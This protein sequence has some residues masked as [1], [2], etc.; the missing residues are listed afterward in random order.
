M[1]KHTPF[2]TPSTTASVPLISQVLT[3]FEELVQSQEG[4]STPPR[5][6]GCPATLQIPH[7]LLACLLQMRRKTFSP[8]A[9]TRTLLLEPIGGFAPLLSITRQAGRQ[10]LLAVGLTPFIHLLHQVQ[11]DLTRRGS[12][13]NALPLAA[14]ASMV[15]AVDESELA[16]V[17]RL[18][19]EVALLPKHSE[20]LLVGKLSALFDLRRQLWLHVHLLSDPFGNGTLPALL[21]LE[22]LPAGSLILADLGYFG[23]AWFQY[24][25]EQGQ[26][27]LS[28][29]KSTSSYRIQHILYQRGD[30][31]DALIWLGT[32]R[33]NQYPYLVRW[34]QDRVGN[35]LYR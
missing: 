27:W 25:S 17:A 2:P 18:C 10:R 14:F 28:R 24:L 13:N 20:R 35:S 30:T 15:V 3:F 26:F 22:S 32:Y 9:V 21:L 33:S 29:L 8:A 19:D 31:L 7:L 5:K 1:N 34:V 4:S 16:A 6:R 11:E 23:F 12:G